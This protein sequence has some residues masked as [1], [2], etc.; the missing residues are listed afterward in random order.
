M[1]RQITNGRLQLI[2]TFCERAR[3]LGER[4]GPI[5]VKLD[6]PRDDGFL[7]LFLDSLD[8]GLRY[9]FELEHESWAGAEGVLA[10]HGAVLVNALEAEAP[11][12]YVRLR[13]PPYDEAALARVAERL[14]PLVE[15]GVEVYCYFK[16]ED[17]PD[18]PRYA[19]QLLELLG[20]STETPQRG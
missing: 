1:S 5:R 19:L 20:A 6:R 7:R 13:E 14:R 18:A 17:Q 3:R 10:E 15:S 16:H 8:P 2:P 4:L 11:F 12:R 9:A